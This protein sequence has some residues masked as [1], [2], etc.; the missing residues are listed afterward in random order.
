[1]ATPE[2][3]LRD[4]QKKE[5]QKNADK[6][7]TNSFQGIGGMSSGNFDQSQNFKNDKTKEDASKAADNQKQKADAPKQ[8]QSIVQSKE[9]LEGSK[10]KTSQQNNTLNQQMNSAKAA[11]ESAKTQTA[12]QSA[13]EQDKKAKSM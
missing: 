3:F 5:R 8:Q 1:M 2:D 6:N 12:T 13:S 7:K 9:K 11:K 4:D 10:A